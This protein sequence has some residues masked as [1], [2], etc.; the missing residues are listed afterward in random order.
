MESGERV[1]LPA[2]KLSTLT[3][4]MV[5]PESLTETST[6]VEARPLVEEGFA[7]RFG[8][9]AWLLFA[10]VVN[11]LVVV[12]VLQR[13]VFRPLLRTLRERTATVQKGLEDAHAAAALRASTDEEKHRVT[14]AAREGAARSLRAAED[15]A[16][17]VRDNIL[18]ATEEEAAAMHDRA[19]ADTLTLKEDALRAVTGEAGD[20][21]VDALERVLA[22]S[23]TTR[24]RAEYREAALRELA[25]EKHSPR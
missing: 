5:S 4:S 19:E 9:D 1:G 10:Q 23:L 3:V 7:G 20:L 8:L 17:R 18:R 24:E 2:K 22:K 12:F 14:R 6:A 15:E 16:N 25:A 21:V 11:F 13:F